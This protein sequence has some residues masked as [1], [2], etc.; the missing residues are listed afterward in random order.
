[1][2]HRI[3]A[4][5]VKEL[6]A[7]LLDPRSRMLLFGAP[8]IQIFL[9]G[10]A[11]TFDLQNVPVAIYD[12]DGG[13]LARDLVARIAGSPSF[14]IVAHIER[15]DQVA[16]LV[17]NRRATL[18][19]HIGP[20]FG[21][22][23]ARGESGALQAIVDGR[24]SN[25]ALLVVSYLQTIVVDFNAAVMARA[26][27][28]ALPARLSIR[29]WYN[30]NL[31]SRWY[32]VPSIVGL[33][34]LVTSLIVTALSVAREREAGTFDQLLVT[35]LSPL[36]ILIGKSLPGILVG[37]VQGSLIVAVAIY[38]FGI[39]LRG[40][41]PALYLGM[42]LF[43]LSSV[44]IGLMISSLALTQ[45]QALLGAFLFMVPAVLLSGFATPIANMPDPVRLLTYL[46]PLRYF[47][48]VLRGV[49]L[50]GSSY[51]SLADQY[52]PMAVIAAVS[53]SV[54]GWFFR[55]RMY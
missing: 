33:L 19:L 1:M 49:F 35:P 42:G 7:L 3:L 23:I 8:L 40:D 25:T 29:A 2:P 21:E 43:L 9:F 32:F 44:S 6:L 36:E 37:L 41:L 26:G 28:A 12:E 20:R 53:L 27:Q 46:N 55:H 39:P 5:T 47:L 22:R 51:A 24:N 15:D 48:V 11:A 4:L 45:Q 30:A 14:R 10:F 13:A 52:W 50:E 54:S 34:T 31:E 18:V 38:G 16:P 17:D